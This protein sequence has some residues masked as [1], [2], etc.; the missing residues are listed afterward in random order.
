[1]VDKAAERAYVRQWARTGRVLEDIR[2]REL[3]ELDD[4][5]AR[6]ASAALIDAALRVPIPA[7]RRLRSGL[8]DQQDL[9]HGRRR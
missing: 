3:R 9:L 5:G 8:I 7:S 2:W 4:A 6:A 1:M